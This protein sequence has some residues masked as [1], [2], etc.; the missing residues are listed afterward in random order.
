MPRAADRPRLP[1]G[2]G[3]G[4]V[5][6]VAHYDSVPGSAGASDNGAAVAAL[7][8]TAR[9]LAAGEPPPRDVIFL[10]SD[11]EET[12][13]AGARAFVRHHRWAPE[14]TVVL[15][16]DAR[17]H[18]GPVT[19]FE[20]GEHGD[21]WTRAF[22]DGAPRPVASS[23]MSAI[24]RL[25]PNDTDFTVFREAG[26]AGFNFAFIEG[27]THYHTALD[28]AADVDPRSV[29][30]QGSYALGLARHLGTVSPAP[31]NPSADYTYFNLLGP[32]MVRYPR[33]VAI[34][35][36]I[37]TGA[38]F[39][40][41]LALGLKRR[42][43]TPFGL[44]QG[45]L[46]FLGLL[47]AVPVAV[48][49]LWLVVREVF[50]V[51]VV[52]GSTPGAG[53]YMASFGCLAFAVFAVL[54]R[55]LRHLAGVLDLAAGALVWWFLL[56]LSIG[57][58][59]VPLAASF[60][61]VWPLAASLALLVHLCRA[62]T[63]GARPWPT[64]PLLVI[65]GLAGVL[66]LA[67]LTAAVYV[68]MQGV[69]SLIGVPLM[70]EVLLLGLLI[71]QLEVLRGVRWLPGAA[72]LAGGV[73]LAV[74]LAAPP[75]DG[76]PRQSSLVYTADADRGEHSWFSWDFRPGPWT[77]ERGIE[78]GKRVSFRRF[79]PLSRRELLTSPAPASGLPAP[80]LEILER[81]AD[82]AGHSYRL[83]LA[84]P[85]GG[86]SRLLWFEPP[87]ARVSVRVGGSA[88]SLVDSEGGS[89]LLQRLPLP[90]SGEEM[91]VRVRGPE[92]VTMVVVDQVEGLPALPGLAPRPEGELPR[93]HSSLLTSDT[94]LR[95]RSFELPGGD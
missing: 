57:W 40:G 54:L 74:A 28:R 83:R 17:G 75:G 11:A 42:R 80:R 70:L 20:T 65:A 81:R 51:P 55:L 39:V 93:P 14:V 46:A 53:L 82:A 58:E 15:N 22:L 76:P 29:Q 37:L 2:G 21:G 3:D 78:L 64:V 8:E 77:R 69:F 23:L 38:L 5:L 31:E 95:R 13:L 26:Y 18:G 86:L 66:L 9:A 12:G 35:A 73:L 19:M 89:R 27:L 62:P 10:F 6:L 79:L 71:P 90:A 85:P 87:S 50:G 34:A 32:F 7:L 4:A 44:A 88:V 45:W 30:H 41:A 91:V 67:P 52:M 63:D 61:V 94:S 68:G 1:G 59:E 92:P 56:L 48:T 25:L 84:T 49:L 33:P 24:Y 36:A 47:L 60:L 43:L 16:F 72:A